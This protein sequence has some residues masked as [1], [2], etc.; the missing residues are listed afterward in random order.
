MIPIKILLLLFCFL[1][2]CKNQNTIS[3]SQISENKEIKNNF[4]FSGSAREL[5]LPFGKREFIEYNFPKDW[6]F[7]VYEDNKE[8]PYSTKLNE[9][10]IFYSNIMEDSIGKINYLPESH[11]LKNQ[12][13]VMYH[14]FEKSINEGYYHEFGRLKYQSINLII[15]NKPFHEVKEIKK[16]MGYFYGR[17]DL[18]SVNNKGDIIDG[19]NIS[20]SVNYGF[21][22]FERIFLIDENLIIHLKDFSI[23]ETEASYDKY[24]KYKIDNEGKFIKIE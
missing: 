1:I 3:E 20:Y 11:F 15:F 10:S 21:S 4:E 7:N 2:S 13:E 24:L 8:N 16:E 17:I 9:I 23:G 14:N 22:A 6:K 18:A 19:I 5:N 12:N